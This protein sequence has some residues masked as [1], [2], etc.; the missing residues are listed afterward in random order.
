MATVLT[1]E[2]EKLAK[3]IEAGTPATDTTGVPQEAE[4]DKGTVP[5]EEKKQEQTPFRVEVSGSRKPTPTKPN[6]LR[7]YNNYT[8]LVTLH[9][10]NKETYNSL[11]DSQKYEK[12]KVKFKSDN[13]LI[14][15][16][17]RYSESGVRNPQ[18]SED[19]YIDNL[20]METVIGLHAHTQGSNAVTL[21]FDIIE[22]YGLTL[23]ERLIKSSIATSYKNYLEMVYALQIDFIGYDDD[24][25]IKPLPNHTKYVPIKIATLTFSVNEKGTVYKINAVPYGHQA[26]NARHATAPISMSITAATVS[27]YFSSTTEEIDDTN[28]DSN[29]YI[30]AGGPPPSKYKYALSWCSGVNKYYDSQKKNNTRY[31][32]DTY[33]VIFDPKIG[34]SKLSSIAKKESAEI[35]NTPFGKRGHPSGGQAQIGTSTIKYEAVTLEVNAGTTL[36]SEI[37]RIVRNSE[38]F[39]KQ[40]AYTDPTT[41]IKKTKEELAKIQEEHDKSLMWWKVIPQV[42]LKGF[43]FSRNTYAKEITYYVKPYEVPYNERPDVPKKK[44][45]PDPVK[46]YDYI[47]TGQNTEIL[48]FNL[49][50]NTM[51]YV[52]VTTDMSKLTSTGSAAEV[53]EGGKQQVPD[54]W[55]QE[56]LV[57]ITR[58]PQSGSNAATAGAGSKRDAMS[59]LTGDL[60]ELLFSKPGADLVVLDLKVVGDPDFIKQD[61]VF[62]GPN[63]SAEALNG[64][65]PMDTGDVYIRV[66]FKTPTDIDDDTGLVKKSTTSKF[67][68]IYKLL[69][70]DNMFSGGVFTQKLNA[71]RIFAPGDY[72]YETEII[73]EKPVKKSLTLITTSQVQGPEVSQGEVLQSNPTV[74]R[75]KVTNTSEDY[76]PEVGDTNATNSEKTENDKLKE[77]KETGETTDITAASSTPAVQATPEDTNKPK[78]VSTIP[79]NATKFD[80]NIDN[81]YKFVGPDGKSNI[82]NVSTQEGIDAIAQATRSGQVTT[83]IDNDPN[84]GW[85]KVE[86]NP[87]TGIKQIIQTY[88]KPPQT[89]R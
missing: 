62:A 76:D 21:S 41:L 69:T 13:V 7:D 14:S 24:G 64:S 78:T 19:F 40:F 77:V 8:Y 30:E 36:L 2:E 6:P 37:N 50:F 82:V 70:V 23:I 47:F 11:V 34:S 32:P 31:I 9:L 33:K 45:I 87:V 38:Y 42:K 79:D 22:P 81:T 1:P 86:Y 55:N 49:D 3:E 74:Q 73:E 4:T 26:F 54:E 71:V 65:L 16:A 68:G 67:S 35:N 53:K 89:K 18:W 63:S 61:D 56:N 43:D 84:Q 80:P 5:P 88:D 75:T 28:L 57:N 39:I 25:N 46:R 17:G 60:Q 58:Q 85:V 48:D 20:K 29:L 52:A 27:D 59:T 66:T 83:Y 72:D 15:S 44:V 51:Y 10:L 12:G